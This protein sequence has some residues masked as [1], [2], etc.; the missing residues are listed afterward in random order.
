MTD[1]HRDALLATEFK[2]KKPDITRFK[3]LGEMPYAHLR[4]TTMDKRTRSLLQV[5]VLQ[6]RDDTRTSVDRLMGSKPEARFEFIQENAAFVTDL[7]I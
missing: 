7:D 1:A 6:D 2:G 4:E 3:G 5:R